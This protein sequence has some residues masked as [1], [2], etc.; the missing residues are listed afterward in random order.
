MDKRTKAHFENKFGAMLQLMIHM[1]LSFIK[2]EKL[3]KIWKIDIFFIYFNYSF[4]IT[5][6]ID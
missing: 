1:T 2:N 4:Y 3:K 5:V 6:N